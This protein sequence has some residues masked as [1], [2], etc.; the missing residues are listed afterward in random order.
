M[1]QL[2]HDFAAGH[3]SNHLT[4]TYND[5]HGLWGG[6]TITLATSGAYE[7][8]ERKRGAATPDILCGTVA[9]TRVRDLVRQV[10]HRAAQVAAEPFRECA[11][12]HRRHHV[13]DA[14]A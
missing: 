9:I 10:H 2:L 6:V 5:M 1:E 11:R 14:G 3:A 8:L 13:P 4:I 7:R 12:R